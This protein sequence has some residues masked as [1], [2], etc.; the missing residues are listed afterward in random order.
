MDLQLQTLRRDNI[1]SMETGCV[2]IAAWNLIRQLELGWALRSDIHWSNRRPCFPL[3]YWPITLCLSC[4]LRCSPESGTADVYTTLLCSVKLAT[5]VSTVAGSTNK[6]SL[7]GETELKDKHSSTY[8]WH[9]YR[10][11]QHI[12]TD[13][14]FV[15]SLKK[16]NYIKIREEDLFQPLVSQ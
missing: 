7:S 5:A 11:H 10:V 2:E 8:A 12:T 3:V 4:G 15:R 13:P 16:I 14:N 6:Q 9:K 1:K